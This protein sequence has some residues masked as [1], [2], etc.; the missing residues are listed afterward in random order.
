MQVVQF[1]FRQQRI[2]GA[3]A[4]LRQARTG[5]HDDREGARADFQIERTIVAGGDLVELVA[6]IGHDA[7]EDVEPPGRALRIGRG[8]NVCRQRQAFEQRHDVDAT[9]FQHR[10]VGKVDLVQLQ[11]VELFANLMV[12]A[13]QEGGA[14][15][16][17]L[18][19]EPEIKAR[20]L[21]L[22]GIERARRLQ[23]A[24]L[25]QRRNVL[26]GKNACLPQRLSAPRPGFFVA[27]L[28][29]NHRRPLVKPKGFCET[30]LVQTS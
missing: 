18:V 2:A 14:H 13:R 24:G 19:A 9:G 16:P 7:G 4:D 25:E 3:E 17:G 23:R 26:I 29:A 30:C 11:P 12:G 10:A 28:A 22:V 21:D 6:A 15:P 20:R 5:A 8:G 27:G 1:G